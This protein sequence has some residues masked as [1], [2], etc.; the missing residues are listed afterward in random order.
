MKQSLPS[1]NEHLPRARLFNCNRCHQFS[2]I[3]S[4]CDRGNS[5]CSAECSKSARLESAR[6]ANQRYQQ[7]RKGRQKNAERQERYREKKR[8]E[9]AEK[10]GVKKNITEQGSL[11]TQHYDSIK[12][13][14]RALKVVRSKFKE[15]M[16]MLPRRN[17]LQRWCSYRRDPP[18][19]D[20]KKVTMP[21][22]PSTSASNSSAKPKNNKASSLKDGERTCQGCNH[23][24]QTDNYAQG[25]DEKSVTD[26]GSPI[27]RQDPIDPESKT[28]NTATLYCNFCGKTCSDFVRRGFLNHYQRGDPKIY[29]LIRH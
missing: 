29:N 19:G 6:K 5:Y 3:C 21:Y 28:A 17:V 13:K 12:T 11:I 16:G 2:L 15:T 4:D 24:K 14:A 26:Q 18:G 1:E 8:Q 22:P 10:C 20:E 9:K 25:G 23:Y 7:T 27:E